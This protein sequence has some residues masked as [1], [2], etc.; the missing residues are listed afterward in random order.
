M[1]SKKQKRRGNHHYGIHSD[2]SAEIIW[3]ALNNTPSYARL[4]HTPTIDKKDANSFEYCGSN[5]TPSS[6]T[7][8][9]LSSSKRKSAYGDSCDSDSSSSFGSPTLHKRRKRI[10]NNESSSGKKSS[11]ISIKNQTDSNSSLKFIG[12]KKVNVN[13]NES[14]GGDSKD[15]AIVKGI[16]SNIDV[17]NTANS[18]SPC[19][20]DPKTK[21]AKQ[22]QHCI[23]CN[24]QLCHE[25][26]YSTYCYQA[27]YSYL[28]DKS[29]GFLTGFSPARMES[30]YMA[31][32][33]EVRRS[34]M[35]IRFG[36]CTPGWLRVPKC[37]ELN[38]MKLAVDL[39]YDPKLCTSL[40][41]E[42][43]FGRTNYFMAKRDHQS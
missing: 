6:I 21:T 19:L 11:S 9:R 22:G 5:V 39:G 31:A 35:W 37:M 17:I 28:Q 26:R 42:N 25:K 18:Y 38:S 24:S 32:Y 16:P 1:S 34:D 20:I 33:N 3:Q 12:D 7:V 10:V 27:I 41:K 23:Y 36:Y 40:Q 30:V 8:A 15:V 4:H 14:D 29:Q 13:I 2:D 43:E